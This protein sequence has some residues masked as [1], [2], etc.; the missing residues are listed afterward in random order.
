M[1]DS[2]KSSGD[3]PQGYH[4]PTGCPHCSGG[5]ADAQRCLDDAPA[6]WRMSTSAATMF[7]LPLVCAM[8]AAMV[9][10]PDRTHQLL[11]AVSAGGLGVL[12]AR[13]IVHRIAVSAKETP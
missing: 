3:V 5:A 2:H 12:A 8:G 13:P 10:G 4:C 1:H 7:L 11:A 6:G 9:F